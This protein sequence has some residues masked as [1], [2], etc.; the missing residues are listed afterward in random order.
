MT[1]SSDFIDENP[2]F[3][4][5]DSVTDLEAAIKRVEDFRSTYRTKQRNLVASFGD[6]YDEDIK[7]KNN[8]M[9]DYILKCKDARRKNK[10][11]D[12]AEKRDKTIKKV[13]PFYSFLM[14]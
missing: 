1:L 3:E 13:I 6:L 9:A 4:M 7:N 12:E 2:V 14:I 11:Q 8:L 5:E 10:S